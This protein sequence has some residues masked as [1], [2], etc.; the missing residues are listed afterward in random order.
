M[1]RSM[2]IYELI[3]TDNRLSLQIEHHCFP[4]MPQYNL[5]FVAE[6]VK[7]LAAKYDLKYEMTSL[8]RAYL[9]IFEHMF[10]VQDHVRKVHEE[11]KNKNKKSE[12]TKTK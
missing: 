5:R 10:E 4:T 6:R 8:P 2:L 12:A 11:S 3:L 7:A 1:S 9:N